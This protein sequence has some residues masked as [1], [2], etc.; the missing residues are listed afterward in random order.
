MGRKR[1]NI[2]DAVTSTRS[3]NA[4]QTNS[5]GK[6]ACRTEPFVPKL[7]QNNFQDDGT[8]SDDISI[9]NNE[10]EKKLL[11][12]PVPRGQRKAPSFVTLTCYVCN[13]DYE[14]PKSSVSSEFNQ[15]WRC[16][17]CC[18]AGRKRRR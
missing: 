5:D 1:L 11:S 8:I 14:V 2:K 13:T 4:K 18:K 17:I 6:V 12:S 7:M 16:N 15:V 9:K 3:A 10:Q